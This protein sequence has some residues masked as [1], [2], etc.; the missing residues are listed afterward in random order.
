MSGGRGVGFSWELIEFVLREWEREEKV[1]F[2]SYLPTP[3]PDQTLLQ[4]TQ[5]RTVGIT[6]DRPAHPSIHPSIPPQ[7]LKLNLICTTVARTSLH[8]VVAAA[9]SSRWDTIM[10]TKPLGR[11]VVGGWW[12]VD[13]EWPT[14]CFETKHGW[15]GLFCERLGWAGGTILSSVRCREYSTVIWYHPTSWKWLALFW[16]WCKSSLTVLYYL[17]S[18]CAKTN[19]TGTYFYIFF[20]IFRGGRSHA[21]CVCVCACLCGCVYVAWMDVM[22]VY[23]HVR[24]GTVR[25]VRY[26]IYRRLTYIPTVQS[27]W[28]NRPRG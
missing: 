21:W 1:L 16:L 15:L 20:F 17:L 22:C 24:Y 26:S 3:S 12:M 23:L 10:D 9:C 5:E 27:E 7:I 14:G 4:R 18:H 19:L 2:P 8:R 13:D 6:I 11:L 28:L 25:T